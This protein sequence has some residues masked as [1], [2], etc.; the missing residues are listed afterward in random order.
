M[1]T[2]SKFELDHII[3][4]AV[5]FVMPK[6][7]SNLGQHSTYTD[8]GNCLRVPVTKLAYS[9]YGLIDLVGKTI[10]ELKTLLSH[11]LEQEVD[12]FY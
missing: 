4:P 6:I 12:R 11:K 7:V 1:R 10:E 5:E 8:D 3:K 9:I 2:V